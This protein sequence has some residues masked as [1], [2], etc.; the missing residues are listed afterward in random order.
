MIL[1]NLYLSGLG[2]PF[3]STRMT[4]KNISMIL[5]ILKKPGRTTQ[6]GTPLNENS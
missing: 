2:K 6:S 3:P 1:M 4:R 5:K